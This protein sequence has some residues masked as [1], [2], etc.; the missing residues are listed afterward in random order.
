M[1]KSFFGL[2]A[3]AFISLSSF[4]KENSKDV[5]EHSCTYRMYGASGQYLGTHTISLPNVVDCGSVLGK[6]AAIEIWNNNH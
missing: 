1:K 4:T 3:I 5:V 2:I 6:Y